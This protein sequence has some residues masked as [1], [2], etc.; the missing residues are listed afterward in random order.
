MV[1]SLDDNV[2]TMVT[3]AE[4]GKDLIA[5]GTGLASHCVQIALS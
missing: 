2:L 5:D 4:I 1:L 3:A